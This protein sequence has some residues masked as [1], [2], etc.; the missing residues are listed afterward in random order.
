[1]KYE[2]RKFNESLFIVYNTI[3]KVNISKPCPLIIANQICEDFNEM[4][5]IKNKFKKQFK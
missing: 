1:M 2:V 4:E 5:V 3:D